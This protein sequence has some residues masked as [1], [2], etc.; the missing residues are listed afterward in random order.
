MRQRRQSRTHARRD[1]PAAVSR[2]SWCSSGSSCAPRGK[3]SASSSA[4]FTN[5]RPTM[6]R[7]ADAHRPVPAH[8]DHASPSAKT[9]GGIC[10]GARANG[11]RGAERPRIGNGRT[12]SA[13]SAGDVSDASPAAPVSV[14]NWR[15]SMRSIM[16][17][18]APRRIG[19][20]PDTQ[21][22]RSLTPVSGREGIRHEQRREHRWYARGYRRNAAKSAY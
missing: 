1:T 14:M 22:R 10:S 12:A 2:R 5:S 3:L 18:T 7:D 16:A 20:S 17:R 13:N 19:G 15:R 21:G 9:S 6:P 11:P 4:S 8:A